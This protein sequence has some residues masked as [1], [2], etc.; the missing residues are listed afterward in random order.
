VGLE[1][2][3][4][5]AVVD[6]TPP[7]GIKMEGYIVER[8]ARDVHDPLLAKALVLDCSDATLVVVVCDLIGV[9]RKCLD[10]AKRRIYE[11]T[12]IPPTNVLICCTHTHTGPDVDDMGYGELLA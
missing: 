1:L 2:K 11:R 8:V 3:A 10:E 4:G 9:E 6:I 7:L 5:A 12:G